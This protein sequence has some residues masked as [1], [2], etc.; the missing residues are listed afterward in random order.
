MPWCQGTHSTWQ[1]I[2]SHILNLLCSCLIAIKTLTLNL[3]IAKCIHVP[4]T[5]D[6]S[7]YDSGTLGNASNSLTVFETRFARLRSIS[8]SWQ[9]YWSG[10]QQYF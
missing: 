10:K 3:S 6:V 7:T 2:I 1:Q 9:K 5:G 8:P 4:P